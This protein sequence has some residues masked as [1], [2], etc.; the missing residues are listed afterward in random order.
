MIVV[1]VMAGFRQ[2][3]AQRQCAALI[4]QLA[5]LEGYEVHLIYGSEDTHFH[6][7]NKDNL[8]LHRWNSSSIYSYSVVAEIYDF[9]RVIKPD[10]VYSWMHSADVIVGLIKLLYPINFKWVMAE[11]DSFYP[12]NWR[13]LLRQ[14]LALGADIIIANSLKGKSY[15]KKNFFLEISQLNTYQTS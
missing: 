2:G 6:E 8:K 7:L 13:Y 14:V 4:N 15:W 11:R 5:A 12:L 1:F 3:G 9:L 10:V